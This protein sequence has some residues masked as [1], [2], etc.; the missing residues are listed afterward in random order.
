MKE[1]SSMYS[2]TNNV[3]QNFTR[4][5]CN[6]RIDITNIFR[7]LW[8]EHVMWTRL[9]IISAADDLGDLQNA[10]QRLLRNP[11]DFAAELQK[12][13]SFDKAEKFRKLLSD[14]LTIAAQLVDEAKKGNE[15]AADETRKKWY[16]NADD[17]ADFIAG[18]NPYWNKKAW[19]YMLYIHL[20]LT[21]DEAVYR[22]T[23]QY[24]PDVSNYDHI[25][26]GALEMADVMSDGIIRQ[27]NY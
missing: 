4:W 14:H 23:H 15:A 17:I 13:Y 1:A 6:R 25:E 9:F 2:Q 20:K 8:E 12:Y 24:A 19:R 21:E 5:D 16:K 22:L 26:S 10:T 7:K 27:F 3:Q 11:S 18:I